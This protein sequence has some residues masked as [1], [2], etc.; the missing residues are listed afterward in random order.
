MLPAAHRLA[1]SGAPAGVLHRA[2]HRA[3]TDRWHTAFPWL[4]AVLV[5]LTALVPANAA[6]AATM[7]T[8]CT[9]TV[10][11]PDEKE[12]LRRYLPADR[13]RFVE[14]VERGQPDWLETAR[15][16]DIRCDVLVIS[17]HY[18]GGNEFFSDRIEARE[19]LPV[20]E[21][22]RATCSEPD[23][24][25]FAHLKEVYLFGCNT[26]NPESVRSVSGEIE[27][28]LL[29]SGNSRGDAA[30]MARTLGVR[31]GDSSRDRMRQIFADVPAIYGFSSVAPVGPIAGSL[32]A[33]HLKSAGTAEFGT[34]RASA[35]LLGQFRAHGLAVTSGI[36]AND[37]Q[38]AHRDDLCSFADDRRPLEDKLAFVHELLGRD[39][40]EV[41][42]FLDRIEALEAALTADERAEPGVARALEAIAA[43]RDARNRFLTFARDADQPAVRARMVAVAR[44]FGWL[45]EEGETAEL[46]A[47][48]DTRLASADLGAA[49]VDLV[50][51][52]ND[53]R[54]LDTEILRLDSTRWRPRSVSQA[55]VLACLG[56]PERRAATLDA[57]TSHRDEDVRDAQV[58]LRHRPVDDPGEL[59]AIAGGIARMRDAETQ[60]RALTA[61]AAQRLSDPLTL[62]A[63]ARLFPSA[64]TPGVQNAIAG[65]LIR[66]DYQALGRT[67]LLET[68]T[69]HRLRGGGGDNLVDV[70]IRR[71]KQP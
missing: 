56:D 52:L 38:A 50:C 60:V 11:S 47:M 3:R 61:L 65:V 15:R 42:L 25:L 6:T 22:E 30:R 23:R 33:Q 69:L 53:D 48:I 41:R 20:A 58:Y 7:Q 45:D 44:R 55:A 36:G 43:D 17:G 28:S 63:L 4:L 59:R 67:E 31:H 39:A 16:Q 35:R 18:D 54:R 37:P 26:L 5:L 32:L 34:G 1:L 51:R 2:D 21:L 57:L 12:A 62:E 71:L 27:R 14:L 49:D 46:M 70:L 64:E 29:R 66:A 19:Y 10:N 13:F 8:V 40:A 24:G 9:V 68:L